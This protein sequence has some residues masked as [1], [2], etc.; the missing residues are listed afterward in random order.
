MKHLILTFF[1]FFSVFSL[2]QERDPSQMS[3]II[4][5]EKIVYKGQILDKKDIKES[6]HI[7]VKNDD[8]IVDGLKVGDHENDLKTKF[9]LSTSHKSIWSSNY[10]D[11]LDTY[12]YYYVVELAGSD[13]EYVVF[14]IEGMKIISIEIDVQAHH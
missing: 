8:I 11:H 5:L 1:L 4:S 3:D 2:A 10:K 12:K 6:I 9:P 14:Y 13:V 7:V